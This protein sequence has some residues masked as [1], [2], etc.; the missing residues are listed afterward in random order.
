MYF[1]HGLFISVSI[2]V[3]DIWLSFYS[4][5]LRTTESDEETKTNSENQAVNFSTFPL[6]IP[7]YHGLVK[8]DQTL[9]NVAGCQK[10]VN[11][12]QARQV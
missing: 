12:R 6:L 2:T 8:D 7:R 9:L 11:H 10:S 1:S 3:F 5:F 4:L